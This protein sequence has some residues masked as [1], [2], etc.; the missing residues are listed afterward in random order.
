MLLNSNKVNLEGVKKNYPYVTIINFRFI[1]QIVFRDNSTKVHKI[2][3]HLQL[4]SLIITHFRP[5]TFPVIVV[6][7]PS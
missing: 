1:I 2:G 4:Q 3:D 7:F 6:F 5:I